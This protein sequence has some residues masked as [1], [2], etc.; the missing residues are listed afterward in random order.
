[1]SQPYSRPLRA[2]A[3]LLAGCLAIPVAA[4][5]VTANDAYEA[6][7][8]TPQQV[9]SGSVIATNLFNKTEKE[10]VALVTYHTG[11]RDQ[12]SAMNVR[13][14]VFHEGGDG[15]ASL[16]ARD[17]G[18]EH[19]GFVTLGEVQLVD[20]DGD[21]VNEIIVTYQNIKDDLVRERIGEVIVSDG[22]EFRTAWS[23]T[24]D[25]DAT[26]AARKVPTE[27]RDRYERE[28]DVIETLRTRGKSLVMTKT[29]TAVAGERLP[30][31]K[32][33]VETYPLRR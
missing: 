7:G 8:L 31:P 20:L 25:Y 32:I 14:E 22:G 29:V 21:G 10:L 12:A 6:M 16:Y 13:L 9:L 4:W 3:C 5:A 11:K 30:E 28:V 1:L 18:R 15:L 26:Q 17:L 2:G 23:G 19:G 24:M 27:R 33:V